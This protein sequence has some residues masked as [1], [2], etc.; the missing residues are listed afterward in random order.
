MAQCDSWARTVSD[1][2]LDKNLAMEA[3]KL[4]ILS[5]ISR[6]LHRYKSNQHAVPGVSWADALISL[7]NFALLEENG[8]PEALAE[9][10]AD[11]LTALATNLSKA[12]KPGLHPSDARDA[13]ARLANYEPMMAPLI[14]SGI[15][16]SLVAFIPTVK[17]LNRIPS[18]TWSPDTMREINN[19]LQAMEMIMYIYTKTGRE[20][21]LPIPELSNSQLTSWICDVLH[22]AAAT[23]PELR[24]EIEASRISALDCLTSLLINAQI[25]RMAVPS[26]RSML[27][28]VASAI[29]SSTSLSLRSSAA[30]VLAQALSEEDLVGHQEL[31]SLHTYDLVRHL[32][33]ILDQSRD[34]RELLNVLAALQ[35]I[36]DPEH[37]KG[38][39]GS[40]KKV[41]ERLVACGFEDIL[42]DFL[43]EPKT[44]YDDNPESPSTPEDHETLLSSAN[45]ALENT[46]ALLKA[47]G[48]ITVPLLPKPVPPPPPPR[49]QAA[50]SQRSKKGA[51]VEAAEGAAGSTKRKQAPGGSPEKESSKKK[52]SGAA[53]A[54]AVSVSSPK[55]GSPTLSAVP[56]CCLPVPD[57]VKLEKDLRK[58]ATIASPLLTST[59]FRAVLD[60][61]NEWS[62][63][64]EKLELELGTDV[65]VA[66]GGHRQ[67]LNNAIEHGDPQACLD[68]LS[69]ILKMR[70]PPLKGDGK[71]PPPPPPNPHH[72]TSVK[73]VSHKQGPVEPSNI[74]SGTSAGDIKENV[75]LSGESASIMVASDLVTSSAQDDAPPPPPPPQPAKEGAEN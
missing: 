74:E 69:E 13:A 39:L 4:G 71:A 33:T 27:F 70:L 65:H 59:P 12:L 55:S 43:K 18:A 24:E 30:Q 8:F 40:M 20:A 34:L 62:T 44:R 25:C 3:L 15:L 56:A 21:E 10:G 57:R 51:Q 72:I 26:N 19:T 54:R 41:A 63:S 61:F 28:R 67:L 29:A 7:H 68:L 48:P 52:K 46:Q 11:D 73:V 66:G 64:F 5:A 42:Q 31:A 75:K 22:G 49:T 1:L 37:F 9:L 36:L 45:G 50:G 14:D 58:A 2:T 32:S 53:V 47:V 16:R 60:W 35:N 23:D 38:N 17:P 6:F